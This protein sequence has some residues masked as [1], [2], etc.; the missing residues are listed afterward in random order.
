M[1]DLLAGLTAPD[2]AERVAACRELASAE[3]ITPDVAR[4]L[5]HAFEADDGAIE[6]WSR[7][8]AGD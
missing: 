2:A 1:S 4:E 6:G 5:I 3:T 7:D 8:G